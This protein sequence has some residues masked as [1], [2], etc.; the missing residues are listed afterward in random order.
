MN[1]KDFA[2]V[3]RIKHREGD[4]IL[5]SSKSDAY[6]RAYAYGICDSCNDILLSIG[7]D[8]C[9][10]SFEQEIIDMRKK[11]IAHILEKNQQKVG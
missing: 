1:K 3:L 2:R 7:Y 6:M 4:Q 9:V 10:T 11:E 5:L 8:T